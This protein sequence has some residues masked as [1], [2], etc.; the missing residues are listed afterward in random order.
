MPKQ[1]HPMEDILPQ[2]EIDRRLHHVK[3]SIKQSVE[4]M[5]SHEEFIDKHC[6]ARL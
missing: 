1:Y 3:D 5:P 4:R 2:D 6:K